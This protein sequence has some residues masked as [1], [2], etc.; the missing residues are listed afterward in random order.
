MLHKGSEKPLV[1]LV[2]LIVA[3]ILLDCVRTIY[4]ALPEPPAP[5]RDARGGC[6]YQILEDDVVVANTFSVQ[7]EV[8]SEILAAAGMSGRF[9]WADGSL[10]MPCDRCLKFRNDSRLFS[11]ERIPAALLLAALRRIDVNQAEERDLLA[12]PGIGPRTAEK[13]V[14]RRELTGRFS[15]L[16]DLRSVPGIGKKKLG[17][18]APYIEVKA[19]EIIQVSREA[20]PR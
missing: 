13:I 3:V 4:D 6:F 1:G 15:C 10:R 17:A 7:P 9:T 12:I 18:I 5:D 14:Q 16:E 19:P 20:E 2:I 11:V 8:L